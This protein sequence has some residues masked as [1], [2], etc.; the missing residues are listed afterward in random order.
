MFE[1]LIT[2]KF[3]RLV[4]TLINKYR[5]IKKLCLNPKIKIDGKGVKRI[6]AV[7]LNKKKITSEKSA[8]DYKSLLKKHTHKSEKIVENIL[9]KINQT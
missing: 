1:Q 8:K 5:K 2:I 4:I 9:N 6:L 3:S 7:I